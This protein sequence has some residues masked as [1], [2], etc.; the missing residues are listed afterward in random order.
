MNIVRDFIT[1][2]RKLERLKRENDRMK[3]EN[4]RLR[5]QLKAQTSRKPTIADR[6]TKKEQITPEQVLVEYLYGMEAVNG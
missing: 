1:S 2:R 5:S 4:V 3:R 6:T